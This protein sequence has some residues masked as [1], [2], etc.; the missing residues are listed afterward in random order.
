LARL[1]DTYREHQQGASNKASMKTAPMQT[2]FVYF[3]LLALLSTVA[4]KETRKKTP[5]TP[6]KKSAAFGPPKTAATKIL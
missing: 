4:M 5:K 6:R 1:P 2:H 3:G